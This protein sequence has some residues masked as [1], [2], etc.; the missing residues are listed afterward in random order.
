MSRNV[1]KRRLDLARSQ[2]EAARVLAQ[3][4]GLELTAHTLSVDSGKRRMLLTESDYGLTIMFTRSRVCL[5]EMFLIIAA[6]DE[7][8]SAA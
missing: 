1:R 6:V 8:L 4:A 7:C 5:S 3:S 2:C